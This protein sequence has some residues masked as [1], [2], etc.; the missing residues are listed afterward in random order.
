VVRQPDGKVLIGGTFDVVDAAILN[1]IARLNADGT[2]DIAFNPGGG[3]DGNVTALALQPDGKIL[4]GGLYSRLDGVFKAGLVRLNPNGT[5]D[6]GFNTT[7]AGAVGGAVQDILVLTNGQ[8]VIV[9]DFTSYNG[10]NRTRVARINADGALDTTFDV[11]AGPNSTV[12]AVAQQSDGKP[13]IVGDFTTVAG[14][15][16]SRIARLNANGS[17]DDGFKP[18]GA[19]DSILSV[20]IQPEDGRILIAGRFT[21]VDNEPRSRIARLNNDKSFIETKD[22]VFG[23]ITKVGDK[24]QLT[25]ETQVGFSYTLE[26]SLTLSGSWKSEQTVIAQGSTVVFEV[27]PSQAHQFFR[28]RR[29]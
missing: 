9:G 11:G 29:D 8:I 17:H 4:V 6:N 26:S 16:R 1:H 5:V 22:V 21:Q 28:V 14:A 25:V 23:S 19:N 13:I 12:Y 15:N 7:G 2:V 24:L 10:T 20:A 3:T 18:G 27:P